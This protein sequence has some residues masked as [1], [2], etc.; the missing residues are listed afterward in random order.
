MY[1]PCS[2]LR[3]FV[4][5][6]FLHWKGKKISIC[7]HLITSVSLYI[8]FFLQHQNVIYIPCR[9]CVT[10]WYKGIKIW[11]CFYYYYYSNCFKFPCLL[12][13]II[14]HRWYRFSIDTEVLHSVSHR[15]QNYGIEPSLHQILKAKIQILLQC[16]DI[17]F[18]INKWQRKYFSLTCLILVLFV[19]FQD[20]YENLMI[21]WVIFMQKCRKL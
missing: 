18:L 9:F 7:F 4:C 13:L 14:C 15:S 3:H 12:R 21:F 11:I 17:F 10:V 5:T 20:L 19:Y 2:F 8:F 1:V 6:M 16:T